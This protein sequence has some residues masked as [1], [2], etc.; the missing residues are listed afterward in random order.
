MTPRRARLA[1]VVLAAAV[2]YMGGLLGRDDVW[3][4]ARQE[5][6]TPFQLA[7]MLRS[8]GIAPGM[9]VAIIGPSS[10]HELWARLAGV[11]IIADVP[12]EV[13]FWAKSPEIRG[14]V[15]KV[16]ARTG[17]RA[18]IVPFVPRTAADPEWR[19]AP[20]CNYAVRWLTE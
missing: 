15:I 13:S 4:L 9:R 16:L 14:E 11:Q 3:A 17:A 10:D 18:V 7:T 19:Q 6:T 20:G 5:Q 12:N 2:V 1:A 8:L